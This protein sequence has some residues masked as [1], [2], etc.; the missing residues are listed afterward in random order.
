MKEVFFCEKEVSVT[1]E[2]DYIYVRV[3]DA[4]KYGLKDPE[5]CGVYTDSSFAR[6]AAISEARRWIRRRRQ[7]DA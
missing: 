1:L 7:D 2:G 6:S 5:Y 4:L 3:T